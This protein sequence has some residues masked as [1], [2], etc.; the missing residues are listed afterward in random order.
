MPNRR[1]IKE[2]N[3]KIYTISNCLYCDRAKKWLDDNHIKYEEITVPSDKAERRVLDKFAKYF[4]GDAR[5]VPVIVVRKDGQESCFN[6]ETDLRLRELL[7]L[8][9]TDDELTD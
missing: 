3:I 4:P 1:I 8:G 2:A 9:H 7:S 6:D 5:G